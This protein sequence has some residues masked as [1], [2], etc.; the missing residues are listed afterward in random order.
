[1]P[2][3]QFETPRFGPA[4]PDAAE[5][6]AAPWDAAHKRLVFGPFNDNVYAAP[7]AQQ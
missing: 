6:N 3:Y 1:M 7:S 5:H 4:R 2:T